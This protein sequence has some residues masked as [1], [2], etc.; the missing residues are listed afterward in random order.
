MRI[1]GPFARLIAV[2]STAGVLALGACSGAESDGDLTSSANGGSSSSSGSSGTSGIYS[3]GG[4]VTGLADRV[5][6][7][8]GASNALVLSNGTDQ[9][10]VTSNGAFVF[11]TKVATGVGFNITV[12]AQPRGPSQTCRVSAGEGTVMNG[13]VTSV[14]VNCATDAFTLGGTVTGLMGTLVL[15]NHGVDANVTTATFAFAAALPS[16]T[17]YDVQ[18]KTNPAGQVCKVQNGTGSIGGANVTDVAVICGSTVSGTV[19][20]PR[21]TSSIVLQNNGGDNVTVDPAA[22]SFAFPAPVV[23]MGPY[24]V[25]VLTQPTGGSCIVKNGTGII[26]GGPVT[27]VKVVCGAPQT[28][29]Y[30]SANLGSGFYAYDIATNAWSAALPNPPNVSRSQLTTDGLNVYAMGSNNVVYK[31]DPHAGWAIYV[32]TGPDPTATAAGVGFFKWTP[33]GLYWMDDGTTKLY[34]LPTGSTAWTSF[35]T[36]QSWSCAGSYDAETNRLYVRLYG[37]LGITIWNVA[38][39]AADGT[40]VDAT[41]VSENSRTGTLLN[42]FFYERTMSGPLTKVDIMNGTKINTMRT[43]TDQHTSSD[44]SDKLL[45][46]GAYTAATRPFQAYNPVANALIDLA[47]MPVLVNHSTLVY[48]GPK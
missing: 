31:Y 39:N 15:T 3:V 43:P 26:A 8:A 34:F 22:A 33:S 24:A 7:D 28:I 47:P 21:G 5:A 32:A 25:T 17:P 13:D 19:T 36:P 30:A 35:T 42:G 41:V 10:T 6:A 23:N 16:G 9:V 18:I 4:T 29:Y 11:P 46:I 2:A 20:G 1:R 44:A 27:N 37:N 40:F 12:K 14:V 45:Y 48:V 38:T